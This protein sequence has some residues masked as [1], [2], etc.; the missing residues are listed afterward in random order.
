MHSALKNLLRNHYTDMQGYVSAGMESDKSADKIFMNANENPYELPG[1]DGFNRYPEPQPKALASAY[2]KAYGV[3]PAQVLMTRGAD[4][5]IVMLTKLFCEPHEDAVLICPPTFGMYG[6]N[7]HAMPADLIEVPLKK[8]HDTFQLDID[9]IIK[10]AY[11]PE[12]S[13]KLVYICSPNNPTANSFPAEDIQTIITELE[14][15]CVVILDETYAEFAKAPSFANQIETAPNLII[16]RTLSKSYSM[17]GMRMGCFLCGDEEFVALARAKA[18][19]AYPL[20]KASVE[21]GLHVLSDDIKT[22]AQD[23]IQKL[24]DERDRMKTELRSMNKIRHVYPSDANFIFVEMDD[25]GAFIEFAKS[26]N[27][28]LRDFSSKALTKDCIRISVGTPE[29]ND[30]VLTLL[31]SFNAIPEQS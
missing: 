11:N 26:R 27:V 20:P 3:K 8:V 6:V 5:A 25:A 31:E 28:I 7:A 14:G 1:L 17:A 10:A 19:D 29:Q 22:I 18:M 4:E 13:I 23:N 12:N 21:A 15:Q 16:L 9:A 30:L 2:A 24:L